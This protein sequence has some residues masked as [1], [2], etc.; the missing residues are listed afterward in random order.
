MKA[1]LRSIAIPG[2]AAAM[3]SH[4]SMA[5]KLLSDE[6]TWDVFLTVGVRAAEEGGG[7]VLLGATREAI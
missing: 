3:S 1:N 5:T 6:S 7:A 4:A 2:N